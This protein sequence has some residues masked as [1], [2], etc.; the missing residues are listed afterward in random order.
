MALV[1]VCRVLQARGKFSLLT[2]PFPL[3]LLGMPPALSLRGYLFN[4][5]V[6]IED[7]CQE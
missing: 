1:R 2:T 3:T 5:A 7:I 6:I 4:N